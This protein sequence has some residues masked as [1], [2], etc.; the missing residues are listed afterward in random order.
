MV[1]VKISTKNVM[2]TVPGRNDI[3]SNVDVNPANVDN[4]SVKLVKGDRGV[5]FTPYVD[6]LSNL[7]WSNDGNLPN[8]PTKNIRGRDGSSVIYKITNSEIE[9]MMEG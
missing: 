4:S 6:D 3:K 5:V 1:Q 2:A 7:S 8:P 9:E